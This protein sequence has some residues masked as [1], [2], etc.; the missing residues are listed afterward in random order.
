MQSFF[1]AFLFWG[2]EQTVLAFTLMMKSWESSDKSQPCSCRARQIEPFRI[3]CPWVTL[4][5]AYIRIKLQSALSTFCQFLHLAARVWPAC[6]V[7]VWFY[8][9]PTRLTAYNFEISASRCRSVRLTATKTRDRIK[10][11][12]EL[13]RL[14]RSGLPICDVGAFC[15][16]EQRSPDPARCS[17]PTRH[18]TRMSRR[19]T[20]SV[21]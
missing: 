1:T 4:N 6:F 5:N 7:A 15:R 8:D 12:A 11:Q 19:R 21:T 17:S 14:T 2:H 20:C 18:S 16:T 9:M 10:W 13:K 3:T